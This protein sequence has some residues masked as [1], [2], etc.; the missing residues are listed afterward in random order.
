MGTT[1]ELV[2]RRHERS[3]AER[4]Y[5]VVVG[6][7]F[8]ADAMRAADLAARIAER[9]RAA[10]IH[11]VGAAESGLL[12]RPVVG[13]EQ[14]E[15]AL[16]SLGEKLATAKKRRRAAQLTIVTHAFVASPAKAIVDVA[17]GLA[18]DLIVLGSAGPQGY[19]RLLFGSVAEGVKRDAPCAVLT[20]A[21][22]TL[23]PARSQRRVVWG[24]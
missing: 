9:H 14:L 11:L 16:A 13:Y 21:P 10:E 19:M 17:R 20:V 18:A 6:V 4:V 7:D 3:G 15:T 5:R 8:S 24:P 1:L 2:S 23:A 22:A 12:G